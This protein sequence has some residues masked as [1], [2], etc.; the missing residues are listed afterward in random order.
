MT[1][2]AVPFVE[3]KE[4]YQFSYDLAHKEYADLWEAWKMLEAKA[5]A[6]LATAGIFEAGAFAYITQS[7]PDDMPSKIMLTLLVILLAGAVGFGV[8]AIRV[9]D[10]NTPFTG[11]LHT[12]I[13]SDIERSQPIDSLSD[14]HSGWLIEA[15]ILCTDAN[16]ALRPKLEE[17]GKRLKR[18]LGALMWASVLVVP[19]IA[20]TLFF[21]P[22]KST[23]AA[24][25]A[26]P[27]CNV[28]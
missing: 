21:Q 15:T 14:L 17:K 16:H 27:K 11:E 26:A 24:R 8:Q 7:K 4:I 1:K 20:C 13:R 19:L 5:Q 25:D 2:F 9:R 3:R 12:L 28:P 18:A 23:A 6:T 22:D 10:L